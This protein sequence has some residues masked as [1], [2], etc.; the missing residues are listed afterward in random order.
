MHQK[1]EYLCKTFREKICINNNVSWVMEFLTCKYEISLNLSKQLM[2]FKESAVVCELGIILEN[3]V[4]SNLKL[5]KH[6]F[7]KSCLSI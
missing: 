5:A 1:E 3:K 6:D 7:C 2:A 4:P